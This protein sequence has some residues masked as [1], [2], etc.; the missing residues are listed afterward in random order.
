MLSPYQKKLKKQPWK[1]FQGCEEGSV[2]EE[3]KFTEFCVGYYP[4]LS[5][6]LDLA[7][8][9]NPKLRPDYRQ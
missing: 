1:Y 6:F 4:E 2:N 9:C 3:A 7:D 5:E 8:R